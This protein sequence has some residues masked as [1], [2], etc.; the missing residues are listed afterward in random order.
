[1]SPERFEAMGVELVVGGAGA[2]EVG[3]VRRLFDRWDETFSLFRPDSELSRVNA[4]P[5]RLVAVSPLFA[6]VLAVALEAARRTDGLVDPTLGAAPPARRSAP[7]LRGRLLARAPGTRLD[8]NGVV[9]SLAADEALRLVA[10]PG[11]VSAGGDIAARGGVLVGLP[12]GGSLRLADGGLATSGTTR[13]KDHLVD[14]RTR[15]PS[16][17][18]WT[19]V[20][21]AAASCLDADVAAKAAFLLS[22]EGPGWLDRRGL[23]GRFRE[24]ERVVTNRAWDGATAAKAAA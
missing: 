4:A 5:T 23:P 3:A 6:R 20:T 2:A 19:E 1:M 10:G 13:W 17:S 22:D 14:P 18:R 24:G 11:F 21:V 7:S 8:L 15:R 16:R 12:G 9:K